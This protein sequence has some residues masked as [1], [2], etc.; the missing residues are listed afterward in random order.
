MATTIVAPPASSTAAPPT[1]ALVLPPPRVSARS[2]LVISVD[3]KG[4]V[5][6][7]GHLREATAKARHTFRIRLST[8]EKSCRKGMATLDVVHD[9]EPAVR[10]PHDIIA[11]P[12][13][14]IGHRTVCKGLVARANRFTV[15]VRED[16]ETVI[17]ASPQRSSGLDFV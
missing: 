2:P 3:G 1:I 5:M 10:R 12:G 17:A 9:A 16:A 13:G 15:S 8:R 11:P 6:R 14:R 7:P 4:I